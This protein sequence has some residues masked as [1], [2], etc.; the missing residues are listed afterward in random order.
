[1]NYNNVMYYS[2]YNDMKNIN[3]VIYV[4]QAKDF[5]NLKIRFIAHKKE[6][7]NYIKMYY[8]KSKNSHNKENEFIKLYEP[9]N[10][11]QK[12]SNQEGGAGAGYVYV[13]QQT[14]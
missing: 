13:I 2:T 14:Y 9:I 1:M 8:Y 6:L 3:N 12:E 5:I 4:G 11:I 10:N 7:G